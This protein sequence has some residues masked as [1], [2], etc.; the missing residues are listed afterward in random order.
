MDTLSS[1]G[2]LSALWVASSARFSPL[3]S[4]LPI[5]VMPL[6]TMAA[7]TSAKSTFWQ[8]VLL[9]MSAMPLDRL[10]QH[11]IGLF[12]GFLVGDVRIAQL[13]QTL[14]G[15]DDDGVDSSPSDFLC[16]LRPRCMR[17][18]FS[19]RKG[20]VTTATVRM[21]MV[22]AWLAIIGD[23]PVPVPPPIPQV[24]NTMCAPSRVLMMMS[25]SSSAACSPISGLEPAPRPLV[26][27]SPICRR[28]AG[29]LIRLAPGRRC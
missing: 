25:V 9:M 24:M 29:S 13:Q 5:R 21:P 2:E 16:P 22:E 8:P 28:T 14:V 1:S 7:L 20:L 23:A 3:A 4:P 12:V 27:F 10:Q 6:P 15:N 17:F 18:S 26:I 11:L 19:N